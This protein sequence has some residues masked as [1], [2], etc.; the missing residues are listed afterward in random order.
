MT[1]P[2]VTGHPGRRSRLL[3][4]ASG[5]MVLELAFILPLLVVA[6][7]GLWDFG[8]ALQENSRLVKAA[9][10]GLQYGTRSP[11]SAADSAGIARA[12][13]AGAEDTTGALT[14]TAEQVCECANGAALTCGDPCANGER[15]QIYLEVRARSDFEPLFP[16]PLV[17]RPLPLVQ[18]L[19]G[20]VQ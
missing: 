10:A 4:C 11:A 6:L 19:R 14:V 15:P 2:Q 12:A 8:R 20:R 9:D 7:M 3:S 1:V 16:Y 17:S 13:R 5:S 18:T